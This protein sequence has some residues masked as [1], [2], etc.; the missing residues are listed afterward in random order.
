ML[1]H[2]RGNGHRSRS[3]GQN[4]DSL[5]TLRL[6]CSQFDH[7]FEAQV[8]STLVISVSFRALPQSLDMEAF[9]NTTGSMPAEGHKPSHPG[10]FSVHFRPGD[11]QS[12]LVAAK[13]SP[14]LFMRIF[15]LRGL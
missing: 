6:V 3:E 9:T 1:A 13:V 14:V 5:T 8:L 15:Y 2:V 4:C 11:F 10:I 7:A 12:D